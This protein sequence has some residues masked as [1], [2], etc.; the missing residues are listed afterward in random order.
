M[1]TSSNLTIVLAILC[2]GCARSPSSHGHD[3]GPG[4]HAPHG[5]Y[6]AHGGHDH[7]G[8][9][10][11]GHDL[12]STTLWGIQTQLFV[13]YRALVVGEESPFAAYLTVLE[14]HAPVKAGSVVVELSSDAHP[15][16]RFEVDVPERDG[17]FRPVVTPAHAG[18][19][20]VTLRVESSQATETHELGL[21]VVHGS[22]AEAAS[23]GRSESEG[24]QQIA[25]PLEQQWKVPFGVEVASAR[26][27]R[28]SVP[29]FATIERPP[30]TEVASIDTVA[31]EDDPLVLM[32]GVPEAYVGRIE[33]VSGAWFREGSSGD[34]VD[35]P[36]DA[37]R[38]VGTE[39]D[40]EHRTLPVR[41]RLDASRKRLFAGQRVLANLI[42]EAPR[43]ATAVPAIA[44]VDDSGTDVVYVQVDGEA[45][46]RRP[47][48]L[49]IRDGRHVEVL[50]GVA[51]G[52]W[53]VTEGAWSV[54]LASTS[55]ESIGHGHAH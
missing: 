51:P 53:V 32:V 11:H 44:V 20:R 10:G 13:E 43:E 47:V 36:A 28:P 19:R 17:V 39:I 7:H 9:H 42:V 24:A 22:R 33:D 29:A 54:R 14:G 40:A 52:E 41:F 48:R 25:F 26:Q 46:E 34:P 55:T 31:A 6:G 35:V 30:E 16:E 18:I 38:S 12:E 45:F 1:S 3:H 8:A 5:E 49:G 4:G 21:W 27:I 50:E 2:L 15:T 37:L 23:L